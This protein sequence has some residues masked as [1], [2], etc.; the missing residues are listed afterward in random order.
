MELVGGSRCR[1]L[2]DVMQGLEVLPAAACFG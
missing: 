1:D 2:S